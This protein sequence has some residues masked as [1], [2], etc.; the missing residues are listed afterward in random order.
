MFLGKGGFEMN[1]PENELLNERIKKIR[2]KAED[3]LN[4]G[5]VGEG[6]SKLEKTLDMHEHLKVLLD[7]FNFVLAEEDL[8]KESI[9]KRISVI[10][11]EL[12]KIEMQ[13]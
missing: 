6:S 12:E 11:K 9:N 2:N 4:K 5:L 10:E 13:L 1:Y 7:E 8:P 3:I